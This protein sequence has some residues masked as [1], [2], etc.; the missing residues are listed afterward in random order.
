MKEST[1]EGSMTILTIAIIAAVAV[2]AVAF[3]PRI[4]NTIESKWSNVEG[5]KTGIVM[6]YNFK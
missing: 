2:A 1:G 5:S 3:G 6:P 4:V